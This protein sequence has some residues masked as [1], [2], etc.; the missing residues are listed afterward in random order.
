MVD[1][2]WQYQY[3][4]Y[5][6]SLQMRAMMIRYALPVRPTLVIK[7]IYTQIEFAALPLISAFC[8]RS[9]IFRFLLF[10]LVID[11]YIGITFNIFYHV[12]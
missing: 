4:F 6:S 3:A 7:N 5:P 11:R 2:I 12:V 8:L 10:V 9:H 1:L